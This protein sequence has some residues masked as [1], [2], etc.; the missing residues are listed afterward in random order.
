MK[1]LQPAD[2]L[3]LAYEA[4]RAQATGQLPAI[5]PRGLTL[6][7][8]EGFPAWLNT[9]KPLV[10]AAPQPSSASRQQQQPPVGL[11]GEVV[12]VLTEMALGCQKGRSA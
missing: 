5:T 4:L 6:F 12:Q 7:L 10:V 11:G 9:W 3:T 8:A 1:V 2:Q